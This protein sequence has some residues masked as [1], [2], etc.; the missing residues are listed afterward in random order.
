M[1]SHRFSGT[2]TVSITNLRNVFAPRSNKD[3]ITPALKEALS[4]LKLQGLEGLE[5]HFLALEAF[6]KPWSHFRA[7]FLLTQ[8]PSKESRLSTENLTSEAKALKPM[9]I[10]WF[11]TNF[12]EGELRYDPRADDTTSL[13]TVDHTKYGSFDTSSWGMVEHEK[14]MYAWLLQEFRVGKVRNPFGFK[15][16]ETRNVCTAW[17]LVFVPIINAVRDSY[18][19]KGRR[20]YGR[21]A[22]FIEERSPS[23]VAFPEGNVVVPESAN[24]YRVISYPR[25]REKPASFIASMTGSSRAI[26]RREEAD[27][28]KE[29]RDIYPKYGQIVERPRDFK[30]RVGGWIAAQKAKQQRK[31]R[32]RDLHG[33]KSSVPGYRARTGRESPMFMCRGANASERPGTGHRRSGSLTSNYS[34]LASEIPSAQLTSISGSPT[35]KGKLDLKLPYGV[36]GLVPKSNSPVEEPK[37]PLHGVTRR[38]NFSSSPEPEDVVKDLKNLNINDKDALRKFKSSPST[39]PAATRP[40]PKREISDRIYN[41]VRNSNPF[42]ED[43]HGSAS[44]AKQVT[45]EVAPSPMYPL[46]AIPKPLFT[47]PKRKMKV[48]DAGSPTPLE[49][50]GTSHRMPSYSGSGY[51]YDISPNFIANRLHATLEHDASY[52]IG[53][54]SSY[55]ESIQPAGAKGN[56]HLRSS[57]DLLRDGRDP[58]PVPWPSDT[59]TVASPMLVPWPGQTPTVERPSSQSWGLFDENSPKPPV[60]AKHPARAVSHRTST[61]PDSLRMP[62]PLPLLG[63]RIVS[64]ENIRG[65]LRLDSKKIHEEELRKAERHE[66]VSSVPPVRLKP[67]N[68]NMFPRDRKG[69]PIG[70]WMRPRPEEEDGYEMKTMGQG[71][72]KE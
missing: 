62:P 52:S 33:S 32:T 20:Y 59:P 17:Q 29:L 69:T 11:Y 13:Y 26:T 36:F 47:T 35:K 27:I 8:P 5:N 12:S 28:E 44:V 38:L 63:P 14:M 4:L 16:F 66:A 64:K 46:S 68:T 48:N 23:R 57:S 49:T 34:E 53:Q 22:L 31:K 39:P 10:L 41:S 7:M 67:Y 6:L 50:A 40:D 43:A 19:P 70:P 24:P 30:S 58:K 2:K 54:R 56:D 72:Q 71:E 25:D 3:K 42:T 37:S 51:E 15:F 21:L 1:D 65:H 9:D 18:D 55:T 60:P 61:G 45:P